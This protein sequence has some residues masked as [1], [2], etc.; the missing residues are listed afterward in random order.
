MQYPV[1]AVDVTVLMDKC[2]Y[3]RH[4]LSHVINKSLHNQ[5]Y[6]SVNHAHYLLQNLQH[7]LSY[8]SQLLQCQLHHSGFGLTGFGKLFKHISKQFNSVPVT[9]KRCRAAENVISCRF[10]GITLVM[11]RGSKWFNLLQDMAFVKE[12]STPP[13][14]LTSMSLFTFTLPGECWQLDSFQVSTGFQEHDVN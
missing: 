4:I 9:V 6:H 1:H 14:L 11:H 8:K 5:Q 13:T 2:Q 3:I 10:G 7:L 12:I